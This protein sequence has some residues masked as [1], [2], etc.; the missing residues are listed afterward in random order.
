[1]RNLVFIVGT[2][3]EAIKLAP[4][5]LEA[6]VRE[7]LKPIIVLTNQH[8]ELA[9]E[10]L[11]DF[12]ILP[13]FTLDTF[14]ESQGLSLL[15]SKVLAELQKIRERLEDS[16]IVVQGDTTSALAAG[17]FAFYS[18]LPL[19]HI[20]AGLRTND[21][22]SPFPEELNRVILSKLA[23]L[24]FAP[25]HIAK[26]NLI[27]EG[28][29]ENSINVSGNTCTDA[30]RIMGGERTLDL[31][32]KDRNGVLVTLHRREN[33]D[34]GLITTQTQVLFDIFS[35][36]LKEC[37]V[38]VIQHPNPKSREA[39]D[40]R[41]LKLPNVQTVKPLKYSQLVSLLNSMQMI[42]TDSGGLQEEATYLGIPTLILRNS[43]ERPE[44]VTSGICKLVGNSP[45][46]LRK[47]LI[48]FLGNQ[49]RDTSLCIGSNIFG[50]GFTSKGIIDRI[51][52]YLAD[53]SARNSAF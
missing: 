47:E 51:E 19:I 48:A 7:S 20:E 6:R 53:L 26:S 42:V 24:N 44:A 37:Q 27:V 25:T 30:V 31:D 33:Q 40:P 21:R 17:L 5:I 14:S 18:K 38:V 28:V 12:S 36:A 52:A 39:F 2:R 23:D 29:A 45:E 35:T 50:D 9:A 43:T 49:N 4:L 32:N 22:S 34:N 1:M 15:T 3:P 46:E 11:A 41:F 16:I 8:P 10:A 13:D